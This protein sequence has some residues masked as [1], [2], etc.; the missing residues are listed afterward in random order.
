MIGSG[1]HCETKHGET[2]QDET[3]D[4]FAL[5]ETRFSIPARQRLVKFSVNVE[6]A[7]VN[8][9]PSHLHDCPSVTHC[10]PRQ[11]YRPRA[12]LRFI[13]RLPIDKFDA[14]A[15]GVARER[16]TRERAPLN[17]T[18][19][20]YFPRHRFH[21][22]CDAFTIDSPIDTACRRS[23][24]FPLCRELRQ[25]GFSSATRGAQT[26]NLFHGSGQVDSD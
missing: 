9:Q 25:F 14:G 4:G 8:K 18:N 10:L 12:G 1:G 26:T 3:R 15:P 20:T 17:S 6:H 16:G 5:G 23:L 11:R 21:I 24:V 22:T 19:P 2:R 7:R 13:Q